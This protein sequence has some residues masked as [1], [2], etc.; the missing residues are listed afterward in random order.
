M[1]DQKNKLKFF[2]PF[3]VRPSSWFC[4]RKV[5]EGDGGSKKQRRRFLSAFFPS[6]LPSFFPAPGSD[7][8]S[9]SESTVRCRLSVCLSV[10]LSTCL[11]EKGSLM[12]AMVDQKR[13]SR[14]RLC[15]WLYLCLVYFLF[16]FS[17][18]S[19]FSI[20]ILSSLRFC[21]VFSSLS[22]LLFSSLLCT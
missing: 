8:E 7:S 2:L 14:L 6:F 3:F 19:I 10:C 12:G 1:V 15:I 9:E 13:L 4:L 16:L 17:L 11:L 20:L 18:L 22:S 21:S 5:S